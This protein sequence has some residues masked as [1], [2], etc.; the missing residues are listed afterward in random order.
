M[1]NKGRVHFEWQVAAVTVAYCSATD[2]VNPPAPDTRRSDM[3]ITSISVRD[4]RR[5]LHKSLHSNTP[6]L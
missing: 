3:D 6:Q 2:K 4:S 1:L 5:Q